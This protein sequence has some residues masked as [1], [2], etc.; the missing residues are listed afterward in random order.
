MAEEEENPEA[1]R[2]FGATQIAKRLFP[3]LVPGS[4]EKEMTKKN[5][6]FRRLLTLIESNEGYQVRDIQYKVSTLT[7]TAS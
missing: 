1:L 2:G 7:A 6:A 5:R 3:T 4:T